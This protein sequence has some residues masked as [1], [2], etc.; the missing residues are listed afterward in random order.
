MPRIAP[1]QQIREEIHRLLQN[2]VP[3]GQDVTGVLL[4]LGAQRLA[5]ELLEEEATDFLGRDRYVRH[6]SPDPHR[7][8][9]NGYEPGRV[10]TAEGEIPLQVPQVRQTPAPYQSRLLSF[11][12]GHTDVLERLVA[13][14]YARGL[15]TRDIADTFRDVTGACLVSASG[16]STLTDRLWEDYEAFTQR[17]LSGFAVEYLFLDAIYESLRPQ[18]G[19]QE[20]L[21]CAWGILADGQKVLLHLT[22]GNK[23]SHDCWLGRLRDMVRRGLRS[24]VSI[25]SDGAPGL[26]RA[27][28]ETWPHSLR[29]RCWVHRMRNVLDKVPDAA[30]AEVKAHLV[31]LRDAPTLEVGRQTATA[32]LARFERAFPTAMASLRDDL[33][34]SLAHLRLPIAHRKCVRSTNLIERSFEEE[35]RRTKVIPRF[36]DERSCLK[37]VYATLVRASRRWQR[38]RITDAERAHLRR[39]RQQLAIPVQQTTPARRKEGKRSK[40][41]IAA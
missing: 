31:A 21:V 5:Q 26:L 11:L 35:R 29:I 27:I 34:A 25:T 16:V 12:R 22:L 30:R 19:G 37:L 8:Y 6:R 3:E 36:F 40:E 32:V 23:E 33:E 17:D 7:G 38:I 4:R 20:G 28:R 1:S 13:E 9:R 2:G 18:G 14:M 39:L 10:R 24:P 41:A 15:S